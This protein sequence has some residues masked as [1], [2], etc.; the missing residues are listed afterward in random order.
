MTATIITEFIVINVNLITGF[1]GSGKT[2]TIQN[3]LKQ[4][5]QHEKWAVLINEFGEIGIDGALLAETEATIKEI[6][7]GCM[8][9]VNG[10]SMQVGLNMLIKQA[11][12]DRILIEPTGLGHPKQILKLLTSDSYN[13]I[14]QI[15]AT[16]C[17]LDARQLLD[18]KYRDNENFRDQLAV[19]DIIIANKSE[20]YSDDVKH[21]LSQWHQQ[22]HSD[23]RLKITSFGQFDWQL[24]NTPH[25]NT[26][27]IP[28]AL[29]H[30]SVHTSPVSH[31]SQLA[32]S[33]HGVWRRALNQGQ[34]YFS[35]GWIFDDN[36][37]FTTIGLLEWIRL[38]PAERVKC[39]MRIPE[40]S[41][42]VNKQGADLHIETRA[43]EPVDSRIEVIHSNELNWNELQHTLLTLRTELTG[44]E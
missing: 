9:C 7:G 11:R 17:L 19:A 6:P 29:H 3:L 1:L 14:L 10:L 13:A 23:T 8:C 44:S 25:T 31:L 36:T 43:V 33:G 16:L 38:S 20:H 28:S 40:G 26:T 37:I 21:Y 4:K 18:D 12:P 15:D 27:E 42:I 22:Y 24:L 30:H 41:L 39:V 2:T 34:G 5:P 32:L 35:C